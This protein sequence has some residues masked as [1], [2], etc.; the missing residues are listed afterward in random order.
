MSKGVSQT[1]ETPRQPYH[2][3][4]TIVYRQSIGLQRQPT[5]D[6]RKSF[7]DIVLQECSEHVFSIH[8]AL[9]E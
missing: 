3:C 7:N 6:A 9:W 5:T 8:G 2:K 4:P 1:P